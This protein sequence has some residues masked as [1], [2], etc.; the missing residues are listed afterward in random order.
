LSEVCVAQDTILRRNRLS[1]SVIE[2]FYVL[3][4]NPE[5]RQGPYHALFRRE[6]PLAIGHYKNGKKAGI[7]QFFNSKGR[8][9]E[10]YNYNIE[11]FTFEAPLSPSDDLNFLFDDSLKTTDVLTRPLKIGGSYYGFLPYLTF[12][13]PFDTFEINT[14]TFLAYVELVVSP[15]GRLADYKVHILSDSYQY[16]KDFSFDVHLFS[17]EDQT[18]APATLNGK[19]ILSRIIIKCYVNYLGG[20]DFF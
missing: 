11:N 15:L 14:N 18:F 4:S 10:K 1:D 5:I 9:V 2:K 19:P 3:K 20:L 17:E 16:Y 6:T 7:W 13:L 12:K 8:L